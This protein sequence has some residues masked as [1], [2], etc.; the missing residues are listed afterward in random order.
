MGA[1]GGVAMK[2]M[3]HALL[4]VAATLAACTGGDI[5]GITPG[6]RASPSHDQTATPPLLPAPSA[7]AGA[8]SR[9]GADSNADGLPKSQTAPHAGLLPVG[10]PPSEADASLDAGLDAELPPAPTT[11]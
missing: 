7:D 1:G 2:T 5:I 4:Y 10:P 9:A 3:R 8:R 6:G 11:D